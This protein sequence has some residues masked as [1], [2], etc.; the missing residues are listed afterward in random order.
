MERLSGHFKNVHFLARVDAR[1][2]L[3]SGLALLA[4][5]LSH[6]G[7]AFPLLVAL[8]CL[9]LCVRMRVPMR[10]FLLR[11]SEPAFIAIMVVLR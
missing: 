2:K 11:F 1:V 4:M 7:Y 5:V 8:M 3:L 9:W 6:G 10:H